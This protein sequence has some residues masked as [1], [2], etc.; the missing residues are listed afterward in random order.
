M[1]ST[2]VCLLGLALRTSVGTG[3]RALKL[4]AGKEAELFVC[5][6]P[7]H[8]AEYCFGGRDVFSDIGLLGTWVR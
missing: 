2:T 4:S 6:G 5:H 1:H 7:I 3:W 8:L